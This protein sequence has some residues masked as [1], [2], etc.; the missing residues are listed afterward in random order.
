MPRHVGELG[1]DDDASESE[2]DLGTLLIS[3]S[4]AIDQATETVKTDKEE[5]S[6]ERVALRMIAVSQ[7]M[8]KTQGKMASRLCRYR[9]KMRQYRETEIGVWPVFF[10]L[11]A[12][13]CSSA[14]YFVSSFCRV[15]PDNTLCHVRWNASTPLL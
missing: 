6:L 14:V 12:M 13:L 10:Y 3:L 11:L 1:W 15:N 9:N 4:Q 2:E 7:K 8:V 5:A